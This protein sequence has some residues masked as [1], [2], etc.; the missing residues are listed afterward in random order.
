MKALPVGT[1]L[2]DDPSAASI[3]LNSSSSAVA[4]SEAVRLK[5][6]A[7]LVIPLAEE[8]QLEICGEAAEW[9]AEFEAEQFHGRGWKTISLRF[10]SNLW[11]R[12]PEATYS[13][14]LSLTVS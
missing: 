11:S 6:K 7:A 1:A 8:M 4:A 5:L 14:T 13:K 12:M 9:D 10:S 3:V 2:F